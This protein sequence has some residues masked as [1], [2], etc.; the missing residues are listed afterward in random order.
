MNC[1]YFCE[2]HQFSFLCASWS[3]NSL[4]LAF[5]GY[6]QKISCLSLG[7]KKTCTFTGGA[8]EMTTWAFK[9][10]NLTKIQQTD[11]KLSKGTNHQHCALVIAIYSVEGFP[12]WPN[13]FQHIFL[14]HELWTYFFPPTIGDPA[15][16]QPVRTFGMIWSTPQTRVMNPMLPSEKRTGWWT[17]VTLGRWRRWCGCKWQQHSWSSTRFWWPGRWGYR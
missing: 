15:P 17:R 11:V 14:P 4:E 7:D 12:S 2:Y 6:L 13:I 3:F 9:R 10:C 8:W 5:N 16:C 1:Q